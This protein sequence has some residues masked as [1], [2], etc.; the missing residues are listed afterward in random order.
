MSH[1]GEP[2]IMLRAA[3]SEG[4]N[5]PGDRRLLHLF[6][7]DVKVVSAW[8]TTLRK[9]ANMTLQPRPWHLLPVCAA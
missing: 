2:A 7:R 9:P 4:F 8:L 6:N 3:E 1:E 5:I